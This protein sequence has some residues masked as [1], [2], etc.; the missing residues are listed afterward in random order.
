MMMVS[1]GIDISDND[2]S[3][4]ESL[5]ENVKADLGRITIAGAKFAKLSNVTGDDIVI[6]AVIEDDSLLESV[7]HAI[8]C[9]LKDNAEG[10]DDL[11]GVGKTPED[12]GEGISYAQIKLNP[13]YYPDAIIVGFDTYGGEDYVDDMARCVLEVVS[14]M[15]SVGD[16]ATSLTSSIK[17]IPGVGYVS[18]MTDDPVVMIATEDIK[19]VGIIA[20]ALTGALQGY[21]N[22]YLV[23]HN[24][25]ANVLPGSVIFTVTA[26][27]NSNV[28]DLAHPLDHSMRLLEK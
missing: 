7:N 14:G 11:N 2:I 1:F 28:I 26:L 22:A 24:T 9:V 5:I 15:T 20:G 25:P 4:S 23:E 16:C 12:A 3:C 10:F 6:T 18:N 27:M 13:D 8:Y 21:K 17:E 19:K